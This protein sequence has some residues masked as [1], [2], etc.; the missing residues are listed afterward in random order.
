MARKASV[1]A[2]PGGLESFWARRVPRRKQLPPSSSAQPTEFEQR[3]IFEI[4]KSIVASKELTNM[5]HSSTSH[6][7]TAAAPGVGHQ[8]AAVHLL[9][10]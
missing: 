4:Y 9:D 1:V 8:T 10:M 7:Q 5:L 6:R 2:L 3:L